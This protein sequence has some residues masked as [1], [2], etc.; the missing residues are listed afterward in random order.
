M[1]WQTNPELDLKKLRKQLTEKGHLRVENFLEDE[2]AKRIESCLRNEVPWG[3][4]Y[5]LDGASQLD[6]NAD[7]VDDLPVA[8]KDRLMQQLDAPFQFIYNSYMVV[9]AYLENRHPGH[10]L[11]RLLEWINS[12][13]MHDFFRRLTGDSQLKK[14]NMQATRYMPG[15]FLTNHNDDDATEG[16]LYAYVLGFSRDWCADWGGLLHFLNADGS[17]KKSL[18]PSF[19]SLSIF[20]VPQDHSVSYV[21]PFAKNPRLALTGWLLNK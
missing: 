8:A 21:A 18:M 20:K 7:G 19:N 5:R 14:I 11:Y 6:L 15:H 1:G 16:R 17:I 3:L 13:E 10:Y 4:A 12:K 9:T 2:F